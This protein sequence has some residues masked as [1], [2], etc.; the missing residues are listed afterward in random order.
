MMGLEISAE[1][2]LKRGAEAEIERRMHEDRDAYDFWLG[3]D[4][5][6]ADSYRN[7]DYTKITYAAAQ[8]K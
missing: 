6:G 4:P 7:V 1:R 2:F 5:K 8:G 3:V